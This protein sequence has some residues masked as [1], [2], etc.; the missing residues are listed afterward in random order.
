[1]VISNPS[2]A[3]EGSRWEKL[4]WWFHYLGGAEATEDRNLSRPFLLKEIIQRELGIES[5]VTSIATRAW[6]SIK[7]TANL[8]VLQLLIIKTLRPL[9]TYLMY[10]VLLSTTL[11]PIP[12]L[13][14]SMERSFAHA[15]RVESRS[16]PLRKAASQVAST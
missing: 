6:E 14:W 3:T 5:T 1:M 2:Q 9:R 16:L 8:L 10:V 13:R 11:A 7:T 12:Q 15:N 4:P